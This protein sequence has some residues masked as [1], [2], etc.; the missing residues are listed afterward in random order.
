[1]ISSIISSTIVTNNAITAFAFSSNES[2][3]NHA[4]HQG[5]DI[6]A[7][8]KIQIVMEQRYQYWQ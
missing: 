7:Q 5:L 3:N 6:Q 2:R 8:V 4:F 1:M